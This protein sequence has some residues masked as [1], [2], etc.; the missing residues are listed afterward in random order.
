MGQG[1]FIVLTSMLMALTALAIDLMLPAFG[2][3]RTSFGLAED[4]SAVAPVVTVFLVGLGLGQPAWGPLTDA[5]G[6]KPILWLGLAVYGLA[7]AGAALSPTL[8]MLLLW[9]FVGGLGAGA[10]RVVA[11]GTVRD[12]SRGEA[13]ARIMSYVMAVFILV[14]VIAPSM[15]SIVL[16]AASWQATFWVLVACAL[17]AA[18]WTLRLP[19][20]L[21]PEQR[22]RPEVRRLV[23]AMR[24][25]LSSR[26]AM[27]FTI[28]QTTTFALF[29]SYLATSELLI[30]DVFGLS[31]WF[32]LIFGATA[33]VM[34]AGMLL[35]P[36][37]LDRFGLR[38]WLRLVLGGYLV[39][40]FLLAGIGVA[41]GGRP[42]FWLFLVGLLPVLVAQ[43]FVTPNLNSAA[44]MPMGH[45]AG[46]A[47]A[48]IGSISTLGGAAVGALIDR[49]YDGTVLP[50]CLAG[51]LLGVVGYGCYRWA[52]AVWERSAERELGVPAPSRRDVAAA[53]RT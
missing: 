2:A 10:V 9:R 12:R 11:L 45:I 37:L 40:T 14:P 15:G 31:A 42:P 43:G 18:A 13:M 36:R 49:A 35:N 28:A 53:R 8:T 38:R 7:A 6:R 20:S 44:M 41:T 50:F 5:F 25:V 47:A 23:G 26:F 4:S 19:E 1:E 27:G 51:A 33:L 30:G 21:P 46:T 16:G 22:L 32:P 29:A 3:M 48:V 24:T 17:G 39:A 34:G 52:D